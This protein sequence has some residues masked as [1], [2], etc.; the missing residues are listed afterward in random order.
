MFFF[1]RNN[2][3]SRA[4][5]FRKS[6]ICPFFFLVPSS[7]CQISLIENRYVYSH[8]AESIIHCNFPNEIFRGGNSSGQGAFV[9]ATRRFDLEAFFADLRSRLTN[10]TID[11]FIILRSVRFL[12]PFIRGRSF[13]LS[14]TLV[15]N[16]R[17][18]FAKRARYLYHAY[19][20]PLSLCYS[21]T[22][23]RNNGSRF[24]GAAHHHDHRDDYH[25]DDSAQCA[26]RSVVREDI[27]W[28]AK[29][30]A[31]GECRERCIFI[32]RSIRDNFVKREI[33]LTLES[34]VASQASRRVVKSLNK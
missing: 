5:R 8:D 29:D 23:S 4:A 21:F 25:H 9:R 14:R 31:S 18:R 16:R 15:K 24:P 12:I 22:V 11:G 1:L 13:H 30:R 3:A 32:P 34:T 27:A 2:F 33:F 28:H 7:R 26:V 6:L 20:M 19:Y 10:A 17:R